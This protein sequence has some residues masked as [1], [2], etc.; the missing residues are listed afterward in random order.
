MGEIYDA[1][2]QLQVYNNW[3]LRGFVDEYREAAEWIRIKILTPYEEQKIIEN[4]D[5]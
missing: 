4:G 2:H 1:I 3:R 5:V